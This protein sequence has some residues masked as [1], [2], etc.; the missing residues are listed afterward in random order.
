MPKRI[1]FF[2]CCFI[3]ILTACNL[4]L[5]AQPT[6]ENVDLV[7]TQVANLLTFNTAIHKLSLY[8]HSNYHPK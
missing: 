6:E 8:R 7:A 3:L 5:N 2:M 1:I 4:P